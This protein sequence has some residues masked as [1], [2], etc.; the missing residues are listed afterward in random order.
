MGW[1]RSDPGGSAGGQGADAPA[2]LSQDAAGQKVQVSLSC[3]P[4]G[5]TSKTAAD[6]GLQ[7]SIISSVLHTT[8]QHVCIC[9]HLKR[10]W[11][12][13]TASLSVHDTLFAYAGQ[14]SCSL[15]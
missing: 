6:E 13:K 5:Q 11:G 10:Q 2:L 15:P 3:T 12:R 4:A 1:C 9:T 8:Y 7:Q 14:L